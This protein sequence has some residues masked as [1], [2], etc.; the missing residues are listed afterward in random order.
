MTPPRRTDSPATTRA[1]KPRSAAPSR[2]VPRRTRRGEQ[3]IDA[4]LKAAIR[5]FLKHGYA[6]TTIDR[7]VERAGGSKA[8]LYKHFRNKRELLAAVVDA[9]T[10]RRSASELDLTEPDVRNALLRFATYRLKVVFSPEH[11]ALLRLIIAE[12]KRFP[13]IA[14]TYHQHGPAHSFRL[15]SDFFIAQNARKRLR[16]TDPEEAV[17]HFVGMLVHRWYVQSLYGFGA[18]PSEEELERGARSAVDTFLRLYGP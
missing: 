7:I 9:V 11:L 10:V 16:I 4:F 8:T 12:S 17:K 2:A 18:P 13:E 3:R 5:E 14:R 6:N 15:L 1:P